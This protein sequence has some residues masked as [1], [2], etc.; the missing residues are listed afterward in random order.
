MLTLSTIWQTQAD[1]E[2]IQTQLPDHYSDLLIQVFWGKSDR[3]S[4]P[5]LQQQ[6]KQVFP[7]AH[8]MGTTSAGGIFKGQ[9]VEDAVVVTLTAF[10]QVQLKTQVYPDTSVEQTQLNQDFLSGTTEPSLFICFV[11]QPL[12]AVSFINLVNQVAPKT[13]LAGG[14]AG[15]HLQTAG[16]CVFDHKQI[17]TNAVIMTAFY[18]DLILH[19]QF[20]FNW[21][22]VGPEFT[23]TRAKDN[24]IYEI[25][26]TPILEFYADYLGK[27]VIENHMPEIALEF[28]LTFKRGDLLVARACLEVVEEGKGLAFAGDIHEGQTVQFALG[29]HREVLRQSVSETAQLANL[30]I[31]TIYIYSCVAR[32]VLLGNEIDLELNPLENL[33]PA[34]GF[35]T[36]GEIVH[37]GAENAVLNQTLTYLALSENPDSIRSLPTSLKTEIPASTNTIQEAILQAMANLSIRLAENLKLANEKLKKLSETDGL[38]QLFNRYAGEQLLE[39]EIARAK[40]HD[41]V[42]SVALLDLDHFK[43]VNDTYGHQQGDEVLKTLANFLVKNL[44]RYDIVVRWGGEEIIIILPGVTSQAAFGIIE[45]L[46][47]GF[48]QLSFNHGESVTFSAGL[49]QWQSKDDVQSLFAKADQVLYQAKESGR[50]QIVIFTDES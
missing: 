4:I 32:K 34:N 19:Q 46:R 26:N 36:H 27:E 21:Q 10:D 33:A 43:H 17:Y 39:A 30:P 40:R 1:L 3:N 15:D 9:T 29:S 7:Q 8:I 18:G 42:F 41:S 12:S 31:E 38:T 25:E 24:I 6:L 11:D 13:P 16:T 45:K 35:F 47:V 48:S 44:R 2:Q 20:N 49:I 50:N 37:L 22:P 23:V 14:V 28:P 5:Q